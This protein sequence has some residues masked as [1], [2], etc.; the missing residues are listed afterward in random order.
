MLGDL[1]NKSKYLESI[2]NGEENLEI[3]LENLKKNDWKRMNSP[4]ESDN[5]LGL[6]HMGFECSIHDIYDPQFTDKTT[7]RESKNMSN[8]SWGEEQL[9]ESDEETVKMNFKTIPKKRKFSLSKSPLK[10]KKY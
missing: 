7:R 6:V 2:D 4:A 8:T 9:W 1:D 5:R 10:V 3:R